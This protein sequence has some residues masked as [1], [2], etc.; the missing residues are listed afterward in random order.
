M[1]NQ[2]YGRAGSF[3]LGLSHERLRPTRAGGYST[4]LQIFRC[5]FFL[6]CEI[7]LVILK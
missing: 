5:F 2:G 4:S 1:L 3:I 6:F 7:H